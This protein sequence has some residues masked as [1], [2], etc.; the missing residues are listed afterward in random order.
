MVPDFGPLAVNPASGVVLVGATPWVTNYNISLETTDM[1]SAIAIARTVSERTGGLPNVQ[2]M[3]LRHEDSESCSATQHQLRLCSSTCM[4]LYM[5]DCRLAANSCLIVAHWLALVL[6]DL[7]ESQ[8]VTTLLHLT[9]AFFATVYMAL[10]CS[11][12]DCLQSIGKRRAADGRGA[13]RSEDA[14][15]GERD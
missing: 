1:A 12:R 14:Q 15:S 8:A 6:P 10:P 2:A 9:V 13:E 7:P 4:H 11:C 5:A 3:A